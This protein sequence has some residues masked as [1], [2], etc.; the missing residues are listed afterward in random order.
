MGYGRVGCDIPKFIRTKF[1]VQ[2]TQRHHTM[3][4][5]LR[6]AIEAFLK[7]ATVDFSDDMQIER[8]LHALDNRIIDHVAIV[9]GVTIGAGSTVIESINQAGVYAGSPARRVGDA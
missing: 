8:L 7:G 9:D 5:V 6:A 4:D 1:D 2:C 3:S